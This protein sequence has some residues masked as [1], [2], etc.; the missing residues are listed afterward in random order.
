[1]SPH[2]AELGALLDLWDMFVLFAAGFAMG[3]TS[4]GSTP[5]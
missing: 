3:H 4:G 1:M 2:T 5:T